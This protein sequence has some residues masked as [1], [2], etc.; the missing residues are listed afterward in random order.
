MGTEDSLGDIKQSLR[1]LLINPVF[2]FAALAALALGPVGANTGGRL[3]NRIGTRKFGL[4]PG[5]RIPPV[6]WSYHAQATDLTRLF[7]LRLSTTTHT[8]TRSLARGGV[9]TACAIA[10]PVK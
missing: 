8:R 5:M 1:V 6:S 3:G 10:Y 4:G 9:E 2:T 7:T